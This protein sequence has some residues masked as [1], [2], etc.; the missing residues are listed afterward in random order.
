MLGIGKSEKQKLN[1]EEAAP[2]LLH[3]AACRLRQLRLVPADPQIES[4]GTR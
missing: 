4:A 3:I 1:K 2:H